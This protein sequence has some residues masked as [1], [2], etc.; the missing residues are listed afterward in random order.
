MKD[1]WNRFETP[2]SPENEGDTCRAFVK[3]GSNPKREQSR[4]KHS[5]LKIGAIISNFRWM[6]ILTSRRF[7]IRSF[8]PPLATPKVSRTHPILTFVRPNHPWGIL[9][10]HRI[11]QPSR[12]VDNHPNWLAMI[13]AQQKLKKHDIYTYIYIRKSLAHLWEFSNRDLMALIDR[14]RISQK[15]R[16]KDFILAVQKGCIGTFSKVVKCHWLR[17]H[18]VTVM[19]N[20]SIS[21][22]GVFLC[23]LRHGVWMDRN[24]KSVFTL[25]TWQSLFFK[26]WKRTRW[27]S[28]GTGNHCRSCNMLFGCF[29]LLVL[30]WNE[31]DVQL[32]FALQVKN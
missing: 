24:I 28:K 7:E 18:N 19:Y 2:N 14:I 25:W 26:S 30:G 3:I 15:R 8:D 10:R 16:T 9:L 5:L 27:V 13:G 12:R 11:S 23:L 22:F 29:L 21:C 31:M 20:D 1:E 32:F 4:G 6:D 17:S